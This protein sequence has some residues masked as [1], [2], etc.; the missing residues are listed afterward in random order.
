MRLAQ[1]QYYTQVEEGTATSPARSVWMQMSQRH[2]WQYNLCQ[3]LGLS[4][5]GRGHR[6]QSLHQP[7]LGPASQRPVPTD[8]S[9]AD[10]A[11]GC[12]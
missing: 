5:V 9:G 12:R 3:D 6:C 1:S 7:S 2:P 11:S 4:V 10:G 8:A